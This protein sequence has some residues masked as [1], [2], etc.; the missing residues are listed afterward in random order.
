MGTM[1]TRYRIEDEVGR[2]LTVE[3]F[4]SYEADDALQFRSE[5]E[6]YEEVSAFPGTTVERFE[7]YSSFPDFFLSEAVSVQRSS[8]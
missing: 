4:F 3:G 8:A 2:V 6:A 1:V 7:R 5:D